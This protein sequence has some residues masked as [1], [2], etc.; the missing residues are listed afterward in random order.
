MRR[1]LVAVLVLAAAW[2]ASAAAQS[3][4]AEVLER[5][6]AEKAT[7][8]QPYKP[9]KLERVLLRIESNNPL[10]R[11]SPYNGPFVEYGYPHKPVGSGVGFGGGFRHDLF[12]RRARVEL[13]AGITFKNYQLVLADFSTPYLF[14]DRLELGV[15]ATYH[16]HPQEDYYGLGT[17]SPVDDRVNY[18]FDAR[19]FQGRAIVRPAPWLEAGARVG[20]VDP[21]VDEG[22]D[23]SYRSIEEVFTDAS[24]PGLLFQPDF[25]YGEMFGAI[26]Y[27]DEPGN[28][29]DGG[30]YQ[31]I[32]RR[33]SDG[34]ANRY[35]FQRLD[36]TVQQ[37]FPIF[38]K[39][40]VFAF[41]WHLIASSEDTGQEVPF[42]FKPTLGGSHSVRS[43]PDLRLRDDNIM[44]LNFEYRWEA[45]SLLD[46]AL[47]SDWGKVA[48]EVGDLGL[49]DMK[50]A[51]GIGFRVSTAK[52]VLMRLDIAGG[53]GEGVQYLFKFSKAF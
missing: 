3:T 10:R 12:N 14:D 16:H 51:Y 46:M 37:F 27:R 43:L 39:K 36:A 26:D 17:G 52:E 2:P 32:W 11:I 1:Q 6:R 4:R 31:L 5:Q 33:Y 19:E 9:H 30:L 41:Q 44:Y 7:Q 28:A 13:E 50:H 47:F 22:T 18:L 20:R 8:L 42:Y 25:T 38:D 29:R 21:S 35:G 15:E 53:G 45:F 34:S 24:A 48:A 23:S 40:R 49:S